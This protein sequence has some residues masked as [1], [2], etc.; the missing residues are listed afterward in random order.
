MHHGLENR[1]AAD[2]QTLGAYMSTEEERKQALDALRSEIKKSPFRYADIAA[3]ADT[4]PG[5]VGVVLRGNY[6]YYGACR[7]PKNI[8]VALEGYRFTVPEILVT[9]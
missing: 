7:L 4:S 1:A 8:R 2:A 9:F 5:W 6:P 3:C